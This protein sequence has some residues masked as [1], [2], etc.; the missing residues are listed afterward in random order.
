MESSHVTALQQKHN[1]LDQRLKAELNRPAPDMVK[2]QSLKKQ[3]LRL[4]EEISHH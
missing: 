1:G 2:V 4:K 3:K